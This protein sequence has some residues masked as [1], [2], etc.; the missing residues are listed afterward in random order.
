MALSQSGDT[1]EVASP[2]LPQQVLVC[3]SGVMEPR[4][5][6]SRQLNDLPRG[7][8]VRP[9]RLFDCR[10]PPLKSTEHIEARKGLGHLELI[11]DSDEEGQDAS[12]SPPAT[13]SRGP[14]RNRSLG[15]LRHFRGEY[16]EDAIASQL[17]LDDD[18]TTASASDSAWSTCAFNLPYAQDGSIVSPLNK[19]L[20]GQ[21]EAKLH[22]GPADVAIEPDTLYRRDRV[23]S[24]SG[25]RTTLLA[26]YNH[27]RSFSEGQRGLSSTGITKF[28]EYCNGKAH[29]NPRST[30][31]PGPNGAVGH[32]RP[33]AEIAADQRPSC[34]RE[35]GCLP[36][37]QPLHPYGGPLGSQAPPTCDANVSGPVLPAQRATGNHQDL[38]VQRAPTA[39]VIRDEVPSPRRSASS[40][41]STPAT[42]P[43]PRPAAAAADDAD[44]ASQV[45]RPSLRPKP[46]LLTM[47]RPPSHPTS[48]VKEVRPNAL[49][50]DL[51]PEVATDGKSMAFGLEV[52]AKVP[53]SAG[54]FCPGSPLTEGDSDRVEAIRRLALCCGEQQIGEPVDGQVGNERCG[55]CTIDERGDDLLL[56]DSDD[57]SSK[58]CRLPTGLAR[59]NGACKGT[60]TRP[61]G[62]RC[63]ARSRPTIDRQGSQLSGGTLVSDTDRD[64]VESN[65]RLTV[66]E[67]DAEPQSDPPFSD[68]NRRRS[69]S[70]AGVPSPFHYQD[71]PAAPETELA[72]VEAIC[73]SR[74]E[75]GRGSIA[76]GPT[77]SDEA[78]V[79]V[80]RH[81]LLGDGKHRRP[82]SSSASLAPSPVEG[83]ACDGE[84]PE[85]P[86]LNKRP[87]WRSASLW[88]IFPTRITAK[89]EP[90]CAEAGESGAAKE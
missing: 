45:Q 11:L 5:A 28:T 19:P 35:A 78:A 23:A 79:P 83:V 50:L 40:G 13:R 31:N 90:A 60:D 85:L 21:G 59:P 14:Q 76:T 18:S 22:R 84:R 44:D 25:K 58:K 2:S 8:S 48:P 66:S 34:D 6:A 42:E 49:G 70:L 27:R 72:R 73:F 65:R 16:V 71:Q 62:C 68:R 32:D 77:S 38:N 41:S 74:N 86:P 37:D 3:D 57:G 12:E 15:R 47:S 61:L 88:S 4:G 24:V 30:A 51:G 89:G 80:L 87:R 64:A 56:D 46:S 63:S 29:S 17:E 39:H 43:S 10:P 33:L 26:R 1:I 20:F 81:L 75:A 55:G 9:K 67:A 54:I 7:R 52:G 36:A 53:G 69:P 82:R